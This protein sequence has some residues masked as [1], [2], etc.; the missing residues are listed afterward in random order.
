[1]RGCCL[2]SR[3]MICSIS[4]A[5]HISIKFISE[6]TDSARDRPCCCITQWTY[7]IA[8]YLAL[9]IPEQIDIGFCSVTIQDFVEDLFHPAG[10]FTTRA[11]LAAAFVVIETS[12]GVKIVNDIHGFIHH[13][14]PT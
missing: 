3:C 4:T 10:S 12:K 1:M 8:F 11:A 14:K 2:S 5:G 6:M 7:S 13:D 9:N